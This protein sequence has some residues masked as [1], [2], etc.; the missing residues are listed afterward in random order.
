MKTFD[1]RDL[2]KEY[3][4]RTGLDEIRMPAI[5]KQET[6]RAFYGGCGHMLI[7]LLNKISEMGDVEGALAIDDLLNQVGKF[8]I[9]EANAH[10]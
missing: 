9:T 7:L 8:W 2:Y 3:L 1:I 6:R 4:Q 10:N 5:Q